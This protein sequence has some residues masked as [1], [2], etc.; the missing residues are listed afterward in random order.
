M[1]SFGLFTRARLAAFGTGTAR[2]AVV[3]MRLFSIL[4]L[5][6]SV[7][8]Q[9]AGGSNLLVYRVDEPGHGYVEDFQ[10]GKAVIRKQLKQMYAGGQ[11][12]LKIPLLYWHGRQ[13][14]GLTLDSTGGHFT[15]Q[16]TRNLKRLLAFIKNA[17]FSSVELS[18]LPEGP[19]DAMHNWT[20]WDDV[21]YRENWSLVRSVRVLAASSGL[22]YLLDLA[23][24]GVPVNGQTLWGEYARRLW[25][26]Y[27]MTYGAGP[28]RMV[29]D[30]T[31]SFVP[32]LQAVAHLAWTFSNNWPPIFEPHIYGAVPDSDWESAYSTFTGLYRAMR[33]AG[34]PPIPWIIGETYANDAA[35]AAELRRAI[36]DTGQTVLYLMQWQVTPQ[37]PDGVSAEVLPVSFDNY[38]KFGF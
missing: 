11:R 30:A 4:L 31:I 14:D 12:R 24:E 26:D 9:S 27:S 17:G 21:Y 1:K 15:P 10:K 32:D 34:I 35:T 13:P 22:P 28:R 25:A 7:R 8:A 16:E 29:T 19:N 33:L 20:Q 2:P 23:G 37:T 3:L 18:L 5:A 36:T 38:R 6:V